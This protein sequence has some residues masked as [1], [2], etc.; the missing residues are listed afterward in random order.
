[1]AR[2]DPWI[3]RWWARHGHDGFQCPEAVPPAIE[4]VTVAVA[5]RSMESLRMP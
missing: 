4:L 2:R 1:M 5:I 3:T